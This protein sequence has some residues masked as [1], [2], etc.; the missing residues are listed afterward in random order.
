IL[1]YNGKPRLI[2]VGVDTY[3]AKTF[4]DERYSI[5]TMQSG[6]H[7]LPTINGSDQKDGVEFKAKNS[8]YESDEEKVFYSL[9]ISD[10]YPKE[11]KV[12]KW[13]RNYTLLR[14]KSFEISDSYSLLER[15]GETYL[16]FM[17]ASEPKILKSGQLRIGQRKDA[18]LMQYNSEVLNPEIEKIVIAEDSKLYPIWGGELYRIKFNVLKNLLEQDVKIS[19]IPD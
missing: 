10:A 8:I 12:S 15:V 19:V 2:D 18:L 13:K 3:T 6:Y 5:W 9:D 16:N 1:Y 7:N 17:V 4:S 14:G 11:A